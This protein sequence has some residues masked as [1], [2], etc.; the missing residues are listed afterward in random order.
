MSNEEKGA[1]SCKVVLIG[2]S[3]V[4]KTSI[5]SRFIT[6]TFSSILMSTTGASF[7]TK[8]IYVEKEDR[9]V[10]FEIW[11]TAGQEKYRSLAKVFY[12][13][14]SVCLLVYDIA[15]KA[16]FDEIKNYWF[17]EIQSNASDN[18]IL[19]LA[20]NKSDMYEFE[21]VSDEEAKA[22]AKEINAIFQKTSAKM[23]T[24][25]NELFKMIAEKFV[26]PQT[27]NISNL[28]NKEL[29]KRGEKLKKDKNKNDNNNNNKKGKCC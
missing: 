24:G 23:E 1:V 3:G 14:A 25:V 13:N 5:I 10:V 18:V 15:R 4:G 20:G 27:E 22:Y 9:T 19:A 8:S 6:N 29:K 26:N 7:A 21:E 16:S 17:K 28:T 12:K 2:E 11:D